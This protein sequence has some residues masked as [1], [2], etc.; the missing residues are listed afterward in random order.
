[1]I[2]RVQSGTELLRKVFPRYG[3]GTGLLVVSGCCQAHNRFGAITPIG[4][5]SALGHG[6]ICCMI[7]FRSIVG[8]S[9]RAGTCIRR[10]TMLSMVVPYPGRP[11]TPVTGALPNEPDTQK[12]GPCRLRAIS[13]AARSSLWVPGK[14]QRLRCRS[15]LYEASSS[16]YYSFGSPYN[17]AGLLSINR[18]FTGSCTTLQIRG[19]LPPADQ[20]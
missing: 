4:T 5:K 13:R 6:T 19:T 14:S 3:N 17:E 15:S 16:S 10:L 9:K 20:P 12:A 8:P 2:Q 7:E 1:M 18:T 11:A